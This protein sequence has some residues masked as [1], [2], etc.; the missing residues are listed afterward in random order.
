MK[1]LLD[2]LREEASVSMEDVVRRIMQSETVHMQAA[3]AFMAPGEFQRNFYLEGLQL[4]RRG[5]T[6]P[7]SGGVGQGKTAS[8]EERH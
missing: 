7:R 3:K 6:G 2:T 4:F 5:L 1:L 8:G